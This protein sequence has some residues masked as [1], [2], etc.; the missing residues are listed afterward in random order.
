MLYLEAEN[1]TNYTS[2][3]TL[4]LLKEM[5]ME[6]VKRLNLHH[7]SERFHYSYFKPITEETDY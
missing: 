7:T 3:T 5:E 2:Y 6:D 4:H 1:N